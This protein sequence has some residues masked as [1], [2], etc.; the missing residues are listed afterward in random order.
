MKT[1]FPISEPIQEIT[2]EFL[3]R[4][5]FDNNSIPLSDNDLCVL[6]TYFDLEMS[7]GVRNGIVVPKYLV[8]F[9]GGIFPVIPFPIF[10]I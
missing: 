10:G 7:L 3:G 9:A 4:I 8:F 6:Y 2:I 1:V 5:I